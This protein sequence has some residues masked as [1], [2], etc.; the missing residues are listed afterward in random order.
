MK[1][2]KNE[3]S[4]GKSQKEIEYEKL[5]LFFDNCIN[6]GKLITKSASI[7]GMI[8]LPYVKGKDL[9][10]FFTENF[11]EIKQEILSITNIDI[12]KENDINSLNKFYE[13]NQKHNIFHYLKRYPGDKAKYPKKLMSLQKNDDINLELNFTE[14][15]FYSLNIKTE[16]SK[17]PLIYLTLL[18]FLILF[19]VLFPIMPLKIKFGVLYFLLGIT[20]FLLGL[21][22][23]VFIAAILGLLIGYDIIIMGNIDNYKLSWKDRIFKQF[24]YIKKREDPC[25]IKMIRIIMI[26]SFTQMG[27]IAYFNPSVPR[28]VFGSMKDY[29]IKG[30]QYLIKKIEDY[31]YSKNELK[32]KGKYNLNDL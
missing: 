13:T 32:V 1:K 8:R 12:G 21:F 11:D 5:S 22:I 2:V 15:G 24:L 7:S 17:K 26:I 20:L 31:H 6:N 25:W 14:N 28:E 30:Y 3:I 29:I 18:I 27:I 23:L 16:K 10:K 9:K 19:V 4:K